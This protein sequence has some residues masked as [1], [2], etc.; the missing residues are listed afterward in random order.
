MDNTDNKETSV[1]D[2]MK[3]LEPV[4]PNMFANFERAMTQE[5]IPE[6]I[7]IMDQRRLYA[8]ET[9]LRQLKRCSSPEQ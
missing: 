5:V 1:S 8:A 3:G 7:K 4:N 6:I 2:L 9:R